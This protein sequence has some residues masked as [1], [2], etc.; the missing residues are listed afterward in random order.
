MTQ[1]Q[2]NRINKSTKGLDFPSSAVQ[3]KHCKSLGEKTGGII[4]LLT[5]LPFL[6]GGLGAT[7]GLVVV[8]AQL[9]LQ[10]KSLEL[11]LSN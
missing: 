3:L 6:F 7:G 5:L 4:P 1:T 8:F 9:Y 11:W 10:I 2:I